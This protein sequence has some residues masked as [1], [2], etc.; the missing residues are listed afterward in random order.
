MADPKTYSEDEHI[1]ILTDRVAKETATLTA[2]RDQLN[3]G[4]T[5]LETKLDVETSAKAAAELRAQEAEKALED[6]KAQIETEREEAARKDTRV[7]KLRESAQHL[8]D[9]FFGDEKRLARIV[10]MK[11]EDFEGYLADLTVTAKAAP[12]GTTSTVP[13]ETAMKGE[14]AAVGAGASAAR[15]FLL[16]HYI[17]P[18]EG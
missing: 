3:S 8:G 7:A 13:R 4:I 12:A 9:D 11:D 10:A 5:E 2:E 16:R 14:P 18:Q 15:G 17:A 6:F 1:A